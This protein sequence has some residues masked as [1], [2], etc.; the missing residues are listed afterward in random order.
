MSSIDYQPILAELERKFTDKVVEEKPT[1]LL[2]LK[3][4]EKYLQADVKVMIFGQETNDWEGN[5][6]H[7]G[8]K[9]HLLHVYNSFFNEEKCFS[10]GGQFWNG[11]LKLRNR[12][13]EEFLLESKSVGFI[14]NNVIKVGRS[15]EKGAPSEIVL[16][17]QKETREL[18]L[19]EIEYFQPS[20]VIFFSGPNYDKHLA[21]I[22]EDVGFSNASE[23]PERQ[24]AKVS[25]SCLPAKSLRTY[26]P[27]YL[28]RND[29][30]EYLEDIIRFVKS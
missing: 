1:N 9:R 22:F 19:L 21:A 23:R 14:W 24:L 28:W 30:Y 6:P 17:W 10:Y 15:G 2:C 8:G 7:S 16:E 3:G 29:F 4:S 11:F 18:I 26:H 12:L 5:F 13:C 20:I 27:N 25:S